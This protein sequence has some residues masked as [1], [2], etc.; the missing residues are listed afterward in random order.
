MSTDHEGFMRVALEEAKK[1]KAEGNSAVGAVIVRDGEI[2]ARGR[3]LVYTT[4]DVT[5][6]A[7]T[8]ALREAG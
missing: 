1:A 7:E 4:Y 8:V 6:H 5:A 3:N 2:V